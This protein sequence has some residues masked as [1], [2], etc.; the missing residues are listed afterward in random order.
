MN[1]M[2]EKFPLPW[3]IIC[4]ITEHDILQGQRCSH[5]QCPTTLA[6][7]RYAK[8]QGQNLQIKV[9]RHY[10]TIYCPTERAEWTL[11]HPQE[12]RAWIRDFD[13][14]EEVKPERFEIASD[15]LKDWKNP[16]TGYSP[17]EEG[18]NNG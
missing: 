9:G 4:D 16:S 11:L 6:L 3:P 17:L 2:L 5:S 15:A 7:T 1:K 14:S 12:L 13:S 18:L 8:E 10:S